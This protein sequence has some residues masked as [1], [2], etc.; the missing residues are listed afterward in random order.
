M[1]S[2]LL[3]KGTLT[4][5]EVLEELTFNSLPKLSEFSFMAQHLYNLGI[6]LLVCGAGLALLLYAVSLPLLLRWHSH[7]VEKGELP[8]MVPGERP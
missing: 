7:R 5:T 3:G 1:G 6:G 4:R 2:N 8:A